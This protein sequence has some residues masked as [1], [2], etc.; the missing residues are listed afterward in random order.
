MGPDELKR[1]GLG[2][3]AMDE[4]FDELEFPKRKWL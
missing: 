2:L 3:L 4:A 1:A